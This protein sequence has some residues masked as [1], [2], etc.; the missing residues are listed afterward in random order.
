MKEIL[1]DHI[2]E[3]FVM[4]KKAEWDEFQLNVSQWE[5]DRYLPIL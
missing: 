3:F 2:H 4:N 1:G 5:L